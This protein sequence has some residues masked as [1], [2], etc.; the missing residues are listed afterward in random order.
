MIYNKFKNKACQKFIV[1]N[2]ADSILDLDIIMNFILIRSLLTFVRILKFVFINF[3]LNVHTRHCGSK[4]DYHY[5][6]KIN[7]SVISHTPM[8]NHRATPQKPGQISPHKFQSLYCRW[9]LE[10][11]HLYLLIYRREVV[12]SSQVGRLDEKDPEISLQSSGIQMPTS[13]D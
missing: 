10:E 3:T 7:N 13:R 4:R 12:I 8:P 1:L 6:L 2:L 9:E 11:I 5:S